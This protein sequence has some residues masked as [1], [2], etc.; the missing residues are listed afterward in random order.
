VIAAGS[1]SDPSR[2]ALFVAATVLLLWVAHFYAHALSK[3]LE[4]E[5]RLSWGELGELGRREA[6][7]PSQPS[8]PSVQ[9][10]SALEVVRE[11]SAVRLALGIGVLTLAA[12]GLR[13]ARLE[14]LG[15]SATVVAVTINVTLGLVIVA[16]EVVLAHW[17]DRLTATEG[18]VVCLAL[19]GVGAASWGRVRQL[20]ASARQFQAVSAVLSGNPGDSRR[21]DKRL[22][23]A[24]LRQVEP[25]G[26]AGLEPATPGFG[27]LYGEIVS[28]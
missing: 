1:Q 6:S 15:R 19:A 27:G 26:A 4:M 9:W 21:V 3:S 5:R 24:C 16:L 25:T 10:C 22:Y 17:T 11:E 2:L 20:R 8:R 23:G 14:R 13:Y 7:I 12:L 28:R 18:P